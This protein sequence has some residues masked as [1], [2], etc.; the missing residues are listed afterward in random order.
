MQAVGRYRAHPDDARG[1]CVDIAVD[2]VHGPAGVD[3]GYMVFG[4]EQVEGCF[5]IVVRYVV[6]VVEGS[7][8]GC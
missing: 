5:E 7:T 3:G 8:C 6:E 2:W 4:G 1:V